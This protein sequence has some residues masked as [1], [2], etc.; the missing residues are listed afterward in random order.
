MSAL[1][2]RALIGI[3]VDTYA[4]GALDEGIAEHPPRVIDS[5]G[6]LFSA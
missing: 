3:R 2:S 1:V 6:P 5:Y 4:A